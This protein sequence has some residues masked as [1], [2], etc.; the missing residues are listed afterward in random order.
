MQARAAPHAP[1]AG[2]GGEQTGPDD[3]T[4]RW[5]PRPLSGA[6]RKV[7][8][9][10]G[11]PG[12]TDGL[13]ANFGGRRSEAIPRRMGASGSDSPSVPSGRISTSVPEAAAAAAGATAAAA[14]DGAGMLAP[15]GWPHDPQNLKSLGT[16]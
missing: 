1:N 8:R 15:M 16:E 11:T 10:S 5:F 4:K 14:G 2:L 7:R 3:G 13:G 12:R 6:R 9:T